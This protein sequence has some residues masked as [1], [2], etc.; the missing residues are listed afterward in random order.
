MNSNTRIQTVDAMD[1]SQNWEDAAITI[2]PSDKQ[3][4]ISI[5]S[6]KRWK[7]ILDRV[8]AFLLMVVLS[9]VLVIITLAIKLDSSGNAIYRREQVGENN[10]NFVA[11]KFRTMKA[12]NNDSE[13]KNYL[14]KY[15]LENAPYKV[16]ENGQAV[17]KV[18]DDPRVTRIG[19]LLRKTNLDELPQLINVLKGEMSFIG[20]RPDIPYAVAMYK[21]WHKKRLNAKPG[22]TGLWQVCHRKGIPFEGMVRLD[23]DYIKQQSLLLDTKIAL[24]TVVTIL[25]KDGSQ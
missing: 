22:I 17:Y 12:N 13:Y 5:F 1:T 11:Y 8:M 24:K 6:Y 21:D 9:P 10:L 20:P 25:T 18:V 14:A 2:R 4:T 3:N 16:D 19:S 23:I 15:I 7:G